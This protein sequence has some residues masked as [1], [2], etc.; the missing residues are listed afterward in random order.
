LTEMPG[1]DHYSFHP[2]P[3]RVPGQ[4]RSKVVAYFASGAQEV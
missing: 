4:I 1:Q 3:K 2:V